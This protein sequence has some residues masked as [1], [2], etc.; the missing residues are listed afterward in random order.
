M[1]E[2]RPDRF[3]E[4]DKTKHSMAYFAF[5]QGPRKCMGINLAEAEMCAIVSKLLLR[6]RVEYG[7]HT[8]NELDLTAPNIVHMIFQVPIKLSFVQLEAIST[9]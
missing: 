4:P 9:D 8:P 7:P 1:E 2:F 6:Y 5:G 3:G